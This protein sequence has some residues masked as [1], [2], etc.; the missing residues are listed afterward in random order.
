MMHYLDLKCYTLVLG[1]LVAPGFC[2]SVS[3]W[4]WFLEKCLPN[5]IEWLQVKQKENSVSNKKCRK[6]KIACSKCE[7]CLELKKSKKCNIPQINLS[8]QTEF[9]ITPLHHKKT[10]DS[11]KTY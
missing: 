3:F 6:K 8:Q 1:E 11:L 9:A 10:G 5:P 7:A 2:I 4:L